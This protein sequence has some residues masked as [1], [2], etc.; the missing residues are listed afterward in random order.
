M[1]NLPSKVDAVNHPKPRNV[2][3]IQ[4]IPAQQLSPI[5]QQ[6]IQDLCARAFGE[7]VWCDYGY[8]HSAFH[9]IGRQ[10][11]HIVSHALWTDRLLIVAGRASLKT[12]YVEY[13]ATEP[14]M[15]GMGLASQLLRFL[16]NYM[17]TETLLSAQLDL[18]TPYQL[19]ALAPEDSDFYQ[20]LGW[21]LWLGDLSIRKDGQLIATSDDDVMVYRLATTPQFTVTE[22]LSAEWREGEWW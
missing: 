21:E 7:E 19:A 15:Q 5:D 8:L 4:V 10:D 6:A 17:Q 18:V 11:A 3:D 13:V 20:R 12:A 16:I 9:V 1:K 2:I 22:D 14:S